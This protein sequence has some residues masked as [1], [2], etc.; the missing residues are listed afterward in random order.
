MSLASSEL[1]QITSY[2]K[3][4]RKARGLETQALSGSPAPPSHLRCGENVQSTCCREKGSR[5][6]TWPSSTPRNPGSRK[7]CVRVRACVHACLCTYVWSRLLQK[8]SL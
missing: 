4:K 3:R 1:W 8:H 6:L 2:L 7:A 5:P